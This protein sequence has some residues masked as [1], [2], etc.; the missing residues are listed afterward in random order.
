MFQ[1]QVEPESGGFEIN[2]ASLSSL[3][4]AHLG[5]EWVVGVLQG[6]PHIFFC[7]QSPTGSSR[8]A[9]DQGVQSTVQAVTAQPG[10][11]LTWTLM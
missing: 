8:G 5:L 2:S 4:S 6:D 10:M 3:S 9:L 1:I 7:S 11:P